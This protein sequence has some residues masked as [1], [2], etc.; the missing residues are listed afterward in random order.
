M[1]TTTK[2]RTTRGKVMAL[3]VLLA[4]LV[5]SLMLTAQPSHASTTFT[6][7]STADYGDVTRG[8]GKCD[9]GT[10]MLLGERC[11]LRAAIQEANATSGTDTINFAIPAGQEPVITP[12]TQLPTITGPVTINGYS[13]PGAQPNT[14]AVGTDAV[15]KIVLSGASA[16]NAEGLVIGASNSTVKGLV[17][18]RWFYG[19]YID[20]LN[21]TGN[22]IAGN[23]IGTDPSGTQSAGNYD[24]VRLRYG[25]NNTVGGTSAAQRNVISGNLF[26]GVSLGD[27]DTTANRVSGNYIGTDASGTKDLGNSEQGV[28]VHGRNNVVGGTTAGERN[29]ISANNHEGVLISGSDATGNKVTGNYIGTDASGTNGLGNSTDGVRISAPNNTV[30]GATAGERNVI[31]AN[32]YQGVRLDGPNATGNKVM[33]N[34]IGT[35]KYGAAALGNSA[36]GVFVIHSPNNAIGGGTAAGRNVISA[37]AGSGVSVFGDDATGDRLLQNSIFANGGLGM[38][39]GDDGPTANDSGDADTGPNNLQNKPVINSARTGSLKTTIKGS[40]NSTPNKTFA[41]RFFSNPS[42][43]DEGKTFIGQKSVTTD[44][45]GNVTFSFVPTQKVGSGRRVTATATSPAGSTSEF[46]APRTVASS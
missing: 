23:F 8:D 46:S 38:D 43:T 33:G 41:V 3:G 30:G 32:A 14:R 26:S 6:V 10:I 17:I 24:G 31:S 4:A 9:I 11:T 13:Q 18:N 2:N 15:L 35:D 40:L 45:S 34:Y 29:V 37:N 28:Y 12:A 27:G 21:S 36:D 39:L 16:P 42:G 19:I 5:A 20:G 1:M 7:D 25:S 44:G 22:R